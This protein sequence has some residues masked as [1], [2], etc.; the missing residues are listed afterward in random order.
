MIRAI[1]VFSLLVAAFYLITLFFV[2][3]TRHEGESRLPAAI[4]AEKVGQQINN[5]VNDF[6]S[7]FK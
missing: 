6:L 7:K 5:T 1:I 3:S 4:E 2:D